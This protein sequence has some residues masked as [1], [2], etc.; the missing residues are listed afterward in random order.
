MILIYAYIKKYKNYVNQEIFF[1]SSYS[2]SFRDNVLVI[3]YCGADVA[4]EILRKD[5]KPD[6]LHLVVGKTGSG[7]T[8]LL[9]L[10]GAKEDIRTHRK[11]DGEDDAYFLLYKINDKEFFLEVCDVDIKQ[12][13][14]EAMFQDNSIPEAIMDNIRRMDTIRTIRI[15]TGMPLKA[16]EETRKFK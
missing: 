1:D 11:W 16:G 2:V 14:V 5:R 12:F 13:P 15:S 6:N 10:I 3:K 8:N 4:K 9:Q 7:K